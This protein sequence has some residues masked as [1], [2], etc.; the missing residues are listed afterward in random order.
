MTRLYFRVFEGPE[1]DEHLHEGAPL[2]AR[3]DGRARGGHRASSASAPSA[4]PSSSAMRASG[5]RCCLIAHLG[6]RWPVSASAPAG[7]STAGARS[8]STRA[9]TS[10]RLGVRLRGAPAEALL[11]HRLRRVWSSSR[12]SCVLAACSRSS[13][14]SVHRRRRS[15]AR[16]AGGSLASSASWRFDRRRH[17]R[18]G[19]RARDACPRRA[20]SAPAQAADRPAPEL[21]A[22][23]ALGASSCSCSA[24]CIY[25]VVK[26]A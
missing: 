4:S 19:Q 1:Q 22:A 6:R 25:V 14:G 12:T 9:S 5:R 26:G 10:E 16:R 23:G 20:G 11:R 18:R 15:T 21:S 13:T 3:P 24:S 17:R 7:G 8:S 2:D